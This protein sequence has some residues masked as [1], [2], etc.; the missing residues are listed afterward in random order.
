MT[1]IRKDRARVSPQLKPLIDYIADHLF[2]VGFQVHG[3]LAECGVRDHM[4]PTRFATQLGLPPRDYLMNCR[5]EVAAR[6]LRSSDL[7]VWR[8]GTSVGYAGLHP[9]SRAFRRRYGMA[10]RDYRNAAKADVPADTPAAPELV[11]ASELEEALA[12]KLDPA[13]AESLAYR[14]RAIVTRLQVLYPNLRQP[15]VSVRPVAGA[16]FVEEV[17]AQRLWERIRSRPWNDQRT[18]VKSQFCFSTPVLFELL[19]SKSRE[20]GRENRERGVQIARLALDSLD[21]VAGPLM[22]A[23]PNYRA[24]GLTCLSTM[25]QFALDFI[26]SERA[27]DCAEREWQI[28]PEDSRDMAVR[29]LIVRDR[30]G[31]RLLQRRYEEAYELITK[32]T[33]DLADACTDVVLIESLMLR[34]VIEC[35]ARTPVDTIA[36]LRKAQDLMGEHGDPHLKLY[37]FHNLATAYVENECH[38]RAHE[39]IATAKNLAEQ[40]NHQLSRYL[41]LGIEGKNAAATGDLASAEACFIA[42]RR[43][44]CE[45]QDPDDAAYVSLELA[46]LYSK[47]GRHSE[48]PDLVVEAVKLLEPMGIHQEVSVALGMLHD[49]IKATTVPLVMLEQSKELIERYLQDPTRRFERVEPRHI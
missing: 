5:L 40:C 47:Q 15:E 18:L 2:D 36:S 21:A 20:E 48:V 34:G 35:Y 9:F 31:L 24:K 22:E 23:L 42:A 49:A 44:L 25:Y 38:E 33:E 28:P 39:Y 37:L 8:I 14:L 16:E 7:Y 11:T 46:I 26:A 12:G 17:M 32:A 1:R 29:H 3:M 4:I 41:L 10:P 13:D 43:G 19:L 45:I 27:L 30:A 6:M